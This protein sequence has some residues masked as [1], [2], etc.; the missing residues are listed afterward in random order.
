MVLI[1]LNTDIVILMLNHWQFMEI[2]FMQELQIME[3][4]N[5]PTKVPI[6]IH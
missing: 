3:S 4:I 6:G 2:I 1:G 5:Q